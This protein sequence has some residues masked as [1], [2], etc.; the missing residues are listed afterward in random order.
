M[1]FQLSSTNG[2]SKPCEEGTESRPTS[3]STFN[4]SPGE[5]SME[6]YNS[7]IRELNENSEMNARQNNHANQIPGLTLEQSRY[8]QDLSSTIPLNVASNVTI[9]SKLTNGETHLRTSG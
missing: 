8:F 7:G 1:F 3:P 5:S 6:I 9:G 4:V 2:S